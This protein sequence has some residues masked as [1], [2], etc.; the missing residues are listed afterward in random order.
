MLST[1]RSQLHFVKE[2]QSV[3]TKGVEPLQA[4]RD[5]SGQGIKENTIGLDRLK[6]ALAN[7]ETKGRNRR[8]RRNRD[9]ALQLERNGATDWDVLGTAK[10]TVGKFFMVNNSK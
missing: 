8:P 6:E 5:E 10:R 7:E 4:I 3:V 1:L 2:I 9:T